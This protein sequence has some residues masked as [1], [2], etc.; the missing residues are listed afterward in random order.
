M[1]SVLQLIFKALGVALL[2]MGNPLKAQIAVWNYEPQQGALASPTAN[3]GTGSSNVVNLGG[4][5]IGLMLRTGMAGTGCGTQNGANAW[6]LEGFDPGSVNEGNGVQF[7]ASTA[8]YGNIIVTWDQRWSNTA[9][10]TLRLQYTTN[11]ST[12]NN[13]TMTTGNTSFCNGSINANGCFETNTVGEQYRRISVN[14]SALTAVNN[15]PNFG[16]RIVAAHYQSTG[17]FRQC[18]SPGSVANPAG[19][20]R[21]DNVT[22]SGTLMPGPN[23]SVMS[24]TTATCAGTPVNIRVNITGGASPYT[25]VYTDG[26]SNFAVNNYI[27]N[28]NISVNPGST[29]TYSIVSVTDANGIAGTGN[30]GNA[31]I[32]VHPLPTVSA[33]NITTC[34]TGAVTLTGGSPAGGTYSIPNP[35]SGPTTTF[36]YTY[37]NANGCPQTSAVRTFTR[38][39]APLITTQ[40]STATQTVCQG[41]PFG[42]VSIVASGSGTLTY[43]WYSN[44]TNSTTGGTPLTSAAHQANGSRTATYL[45]FSTTIGTL[46]Y[47]VVVTNSCTSVKSVNATGAFVVTPPTVAGTVTDNQ[48]ICAG[49]TPGDLTLSGQSGLVVRW[50]KALDAGFTTGV[51]GIASTSTTLTGA[52]MGTI[53]QTTYFRAFVQNSGCSELPT[54]PV[55]VEIKSTTWNG[56]WT[57]GPP[58]ASVTAIF[59]ADYLSAGDLEACSATILAGNVVF[60][61]DH[62]LTLQDG[63]YV[64]GGT[65]TFENNASLVQ[66][67]DVAN[68]GN[69]QYKRNTT[70]VLRYD[71]TYWSSPVEM[72]ILASFSPLTLSDKYFWWNPTIYNWELITTPG[73]TPMEV[74]KGYIIR[75][76]QTFAI[77]STDIFE[78]VFT[79]VPNNGDYPVSITVTGANNLNLLGNPYPSALDADAFMSDPDN[80]AAIGTGTSIYLWTHNSPILNYE[81]AANDY[82]T[83]NYTGGTGTAAAVATGI[84]NNIPNGYIAAGQ[85]F[86]VKGLASGSAIFKNS[87]RVGG[88]NGQFFRTQ[89][90]QKERVWLEL[91]NANGAYKQALVGYIENATDGIDAGFDAELI[92]AGNPVAFY[93][94]IDQTKLTIQGRALP[95]DASHRIPM[96]YRTNVA[97]NFKIDLAQFD[98]AFADREIY[99]EDLLLGIVHNLKQGAYGFATQ[100][101]TFDTRFVLRFTD[102]ALGTVKQTSKDGLVV[103]TQ[104]D[105]VL[106]HSGP[107][108]IQDVKV[109]DVRGR[110]LAGKDRV[111]ATQTAID[112]PAARQVLL[113]QVT[114]E[115]GEIAHR[116]IVH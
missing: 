63:L 51:Q 66:I 70:P 2:L 108:K 28:T 104:A 103:Y 76:P 14:L 3:I 78:G 4:G 94:L 81:Y 21:F 31:V 95:F 90:R 49:S 1:K 96:G 97:G 16:V 116:K 92:E 18:L 64:T 42:V 39:T 25:L 35:Y 44:T 93:S 73:I 60:D 29:R 82:A 75:A 77:A 54:A 40:P 68:T 27:S 74:G 107:Q 102:V 37:T 17:Q 33:N 89:T 114:T 99:V 57:D 105:Q 55:E 115:S 86:M 88:S 6:A 65:M 11:G 112:L 72:Q 41:A 56:T 5:A 58:D 109:F 15:N 80:G 36:T 7:N 61:T 59:A 98:E 45:P 62:T 23:P 32:T 8:T 30:S 13:F 85:G 87:M 24:G 71:Y 91:K 106:V 26:T 101:G 79:G 67:N 84:N 53:T 83:Y 47:Y 38:N 113:V 20:W 12:W 100:V 43:Q 22:I 110:L 50:Q 69:I 111:N 9:A 10:N 46:Y 48:I 52:L 19:T 34:A